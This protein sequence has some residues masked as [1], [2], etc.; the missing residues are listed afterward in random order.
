MATKKTEYQPG[1][2]QLLARF[3]LP[4]ESKQERLAIQYVATVVASLPLSPRRV[5]RLKT[6]VAEATMNAIEHGHGFNAEKSVSLLLSTT[7]TALVVHIINEGDNPVLP[8]RPLD[9]AAKVAGTDTPRGWG[10]FLMQN[11]VDE[12][13]VYQLCQDEKVQQVVELILYLE[14]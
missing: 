13:N 11:L 14:K 12:V 7:D 6:A 3:E 5:E 8:P 10:L 2:P 4:S 1:K 9:L